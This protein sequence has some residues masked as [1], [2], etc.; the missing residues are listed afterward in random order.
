MQILEDIIRVTK[1]EWNFL[2]DAFKVDMRAID[3][4]GDPLPKED[5]EREFSIGNGEEMAELIRTHDFKV[6]TNPITYTFEFDNGEKIY[7]NLYI[8]E[9][10]GLVEWTFDSDQD[11]EAEYDLE[12]RTE[13]DQYNKHTGEIDIKY[14][15]MFEIV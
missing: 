12:L 10:G 7:L 14:V 8:E 9:W 1:D 11:G 5:L 4:N 13:W 3:E 2:Q 15:C 6:G